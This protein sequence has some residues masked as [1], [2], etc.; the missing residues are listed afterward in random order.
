MRD[1]SVHLDKGSSC[2]RKDKKYQRS[3]KDRHD[4]IEVVGECVDNLHD[5]ICIIYLAS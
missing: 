4:D 5:I 3:Y 2:E 1:S